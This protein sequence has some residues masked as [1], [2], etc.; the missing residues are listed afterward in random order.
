M[1]PFIRL[2][3]LAVLIKTSLLAGSR[4]NEA[5]V[6]PN[7]LFITVDDL[8]PELGAYGKNHVI[9]PNIDRLA[10][11]GIVFQ[12]AYCQ[13]AICNA[14]RASFLTGLRPDSTGVYDLVTHFRKKVPDVVTLPQIFKKHG[15][16]TQAI[17]KIYHPAF[18]GFGI[19]SDLNDPASW[20][21]AAWLGSPRYYY[22][23]LGEKLAREAFNAAINSPQA[24]ELNW[25][26]EAKAARQV[27]RPNSDDTSVREEEWKT[28]NV[29]ALATEAPDVSD[30]TLY[31]GQV[32]ERAI[33]ALRRQKQRQDAT[34]AERSQPFFLAVGFLKPH[35]PFIAPRKYWDLYDPEKLDV[36]ANPGPPYDAPAPALATGLDELRDTYPLDVRVPAPDEQGLDPQVP[37]VLPKSGPLTREQVIQLRRGYYACISYVDAQVGRI[38]AELERLDLARNTIIVLVGDHGFSLGEHGLWGKLTNF[39]D[40]TRSPL[41][42]SSPGR[43]AG[44][45]QTSALVELVD[46]YPTLC[47][48]AGLP[49]PDRLEGTSLV[50]L[51]DDP[52]REWKTA[53]FSQYPRKGLMGYTMRTDRYRYTVWQSTDDARTNVGTE[54]Y[55]HTIDPA[56]TLNLARLPQNAAL[57]AALDDQLKRGWRGAVSPVMNKHSLPARPNQ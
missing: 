28:V 46:I 22:S 15:Y 11:R 21:E 37:Y 38:V 8:R 41:I 57:V 42:I 35:L 32:A 29:R 17:G 53:A 51:L 43:A 48:L 54:L 31:D 26:K 5:Q 12:R 2:L 20:S 56:E 13:Q 10:A 50:P 33:A 14:S 4:M 39:E 24:S 44:G 55:D 9:S 23:P 30:E 25:I 1:N 18:P 34:H 3:S 40:A 49:K 19:G 45:A 27:A 52:G 36:A 7:V 16:H 47:D 6:A